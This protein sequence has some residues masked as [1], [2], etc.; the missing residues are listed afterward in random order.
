MGASPAGPP[1]GSASAL[2]PTTL[3]LVFVG[4]ALGTGLRALLTSRPDAVW[5]TLAVN[6]V[7]SFALGWLLA[8]LSSRSGRGA[9]GA[10]A[11]LGTGFLGGFTTYSALAWQSLDVLG[12]GLGS[13]LLWTFGL[14]IGSVA[15]GVLAALAGLALGRRTAS[16][17][18]RAEGL[19]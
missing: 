4:G 12:S 19:S 8:A 11:V 14:G 15:L 18:G 2:S 10:K 1:V 13:D 5:W 6:V 16:G 9:S 3:G 7:G 17:S